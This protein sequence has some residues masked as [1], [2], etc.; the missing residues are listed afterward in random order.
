MRKTQ[1]FL[2]NCR[3]P[4][5]KV[6][7]STWTQAPTYKKAFHDFAYNMATCL[8]YFQNQVHNLRLQFSRPLPG[9]GG[10]QQGGQVGNAKHE[11][12]LVETEKNICFFFMHNCTI[13]VFSLPPAGEVPSP[14]PRCCRRAEGWKSSD[15]SR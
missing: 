5:E 15:R 10:R 7:A 3:S 4:N 1:W 11:A 13:R 9:K 8:I 12:V 2:T 14:P 6:P